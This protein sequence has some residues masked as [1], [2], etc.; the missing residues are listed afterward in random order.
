MPADDLQHVI[1]IVGDAAGEL[2]DRFHLLR[3][4]QGRLA[5]RQ[6]FL[7]AP[8]GGKGLVALAT[9]DAG[10]AVVTHARHQLARIRPL[11]HVVAGADGKGLG[12]D[13]GIVLGREQD[14][15][16]VLG[17]GMFPQSGD[18][19]E[20]VEAAGHAQVDQHHG[21]VD[22]ACY[23]DSA[24]RAG[25]IHQLMTDTSSETV[26]NDVLGKRFIVNQQHGTA[27]VVFDHCNCIAFRLEWNV[28]QK[29]T[30]R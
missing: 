10:A 28:L 9:R 26:G 5:R 1:E 2:A 7:A 4:L 17:V 11:D 21:R 13:V 22:L 16:D 23:I 20:A 14:D 18:D 25:F 8:Q 15:R 29:N 12:L 3:L 19:G 27:G 30:K 6:L 24:L